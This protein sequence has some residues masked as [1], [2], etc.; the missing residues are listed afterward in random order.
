MSQPMLTEFVTLVLQ[1]EMLG[2]AAYFK[3]QEPIGKCI[4]DGSSSGVAAD[5][6]KTNYY[7]STTCGGTNT[8]VMTLPK[9][10]TE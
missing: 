4:K 5:L 6:K 7:G 3:V 10:C 1:Q 8:G 2:T 9:T